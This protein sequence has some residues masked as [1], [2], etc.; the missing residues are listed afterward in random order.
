MIAPFVILTGNRPAV[1]AWK[2]RVVTTP[3]PDAPSDPVGRRSSDLRDAA[4]RVVATHQCYELLALGQKVAIGN[5]DNFQSRFVVRH[6]KR[7]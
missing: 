2:V 6:L 4:S 5:I 3:W 7:N 1:F